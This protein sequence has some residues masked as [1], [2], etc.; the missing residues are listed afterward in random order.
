MRE[1][2]A[3][4]RA[5]LQTFQIQHQITGL[6]RGCCL[7]LCCQAQIPDRQGAFSATVR[8]QNRIEEAVHSGFFDRQA[9]RH[10]FTRSL[11]RLQ[12]RCVHLCAF[13]RIVDCLPAV[14]AEIEYRR[15]R[16]REGVDPLHLHRH[17][18]IRIGRHVD[19][20][21][22]GCPIHRI[23]FGPVAPDLPVEG[24]RYLASLPVMRERTAS[25]RASLQAFQ[26]QHQI[27]GL[28][29]W[30]HYVNGAAKHKD[31]QGGEN[32]KQPLN[33]RLREPVFQ[34]PHS[35]SILSGIF[36]YLPRANDFEVSTG[37]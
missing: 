20:R 13:P 12:L 9:H 29:P 23:P 25:L 2:T 3:S 30:R 26:I 1:H 8:Q 6:F 33:S 35:L 27:T 7:I 32:G 37:L 16:H 18:Y 14:V 24:D 22:V 4:L 11:Q 21:L 34:T 5:S 31:D 17:R 19:R 15:R 28:C 36:A 10:P